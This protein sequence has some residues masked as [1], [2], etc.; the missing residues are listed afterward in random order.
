MSAKRQNRTMTRLSSTA[1]SICDSSAARG[2][3]LIGGF[4]WQRSSFQLEYH[5]AID[6]LSGT[7]ARPAAAND[8]CHR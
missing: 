4:D 8:G 2:W 3:R 6:D 7:A 5:A 1:V